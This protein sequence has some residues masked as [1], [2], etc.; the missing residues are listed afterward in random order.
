VWLANLT[1]LITIGIVW[2]KTK[3]QVK[4]DTKQ[5]VI[6]AIKR[7]IGYPII[8]ILVWAVSTAYDTLTTLFPGQEFEGYDV[9]KFLATVYPCS[10]GFFIAIYFF[11]VQ[12]DVRNDSIEVIRGYF[13]TGKYTPKSASQ[14]GRRRASLYSR[15]VFIDASDSF[16]MGSESS[17][18]TGSSLRSSIDENT[19]DDNN[20]MLEANDTEATTTTVSVVGDLIVEDL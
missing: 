16:R 14:G 6:L 15:K 17:Y 2:F 9:M 11:I 12:S 20:I 7:L 1:I 4:E 8:I 5:D 10:Q 13:T 18:R 3:Y 19:K